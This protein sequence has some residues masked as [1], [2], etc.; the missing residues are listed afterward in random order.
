VIEGM[1]DPAK[2]WLQRLIVL[3][4]VLTLLIVGLFSATNLVAYRFLTGP[5]QALIRVKDLQITVL[6]MDEALTKSARLAAA[7]GDPEWE[8]RYRRLEPQLA[9]AMAEVQRLELAPAYGQAVARSDAANRERVAMEQHAF[10]LLRQ[11]QGA[12]AQV[13]LSGEPYQA[14]KSDFA[15]GIADIGRLLKQ[16][17]DAVQ[18]DRRVRLLWSLALA[19]LLTPVLIVGWWLV[20]RAARRWQGAVLESTRQMN[21]KTE[22][23]AELNRQLDAKVSERTQELRDSA[24]ASLNMMEDAIRERENTARAHEKLDYLGS[25]DALT[26]LANQALFLKRVQE[27]LLAGRD[28]ARKKAIVVL[29]VEH[30][31]SINDAFGQRAGDALLKQ[32]AERLVQ[33]GGGDATRFARVGPDRFAI[34]ASPRDSAEQVAR[35]TERRLE[36]IFRSPFQVGD[37][38]LRVAVRAGIAL[39]PDDGTDAETLLR[40]AEAALRKAKS[41][42]E[43][44]LFFQPA[45]LEHLAEDLSLETR[46]RQAVDHE[47]FVLHYQPKV[48]LQTGK[49]TGAEGLIRWNDP[50]TGV[51]VP[52]HRFIPV[53][54]KTGLI[55]DVGRWA[56]RQAVAD[57]R[58]WRSAGL[59][60]VPIAVNVSP[61]QLRNRGF[62]AEVEQAIGGDAQAAAGL[63]L[64]I[65][66]SL[67]MEDV[68]HSVASLQVIRAMGVGIAIDDFGTGFSSLSYLSK[69][70]VD[71]LKIDRSFVTDMTAGPEGLAVVSSIVAL[72]HA[73]KLKV[74]AEGVENDEQARLLRLMGCDEM[75]G[76]LFSAPLP[77][78]AFVAR[79]LG[80]AAPV[81][82]RALKEPR[83]KAGRAAAG[84]FPS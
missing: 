74:V 15:A 65:T 47:E 33:A 38:A 1:L 31:E 83:A 11:G 24:I 84:P 36:G 60:A 25:Y 68:K 80:P 63:E 45:M 44:Y 5:M 56:L 43:P 28:D 26:G 10:D 77:A 40:G 29:D 64:E 27:R 55:H 76:Y 39:F 32:V 51:L 61:L 82:E 71:T 9:Q 79:H 78:A 54:E 73:L 18:E 53:L 50:R 62:I 48:N 21:R 7:T 52:P 3:S 69:L 6:V 13:L 17:I 16:D 42:G 12:A 66:E 2:N 75:Q 49:V 20:L 41:T 67:I 22:E 4:A 46:L 72:V 23:L 70:P 14:R 57:H 58:H 37:G 34:R 81:P 35:D 8:A 59:A 19:V 30:F